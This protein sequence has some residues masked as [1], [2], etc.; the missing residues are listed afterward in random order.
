MLFLYL[1]PLLSL[2]AVDAQ[3]VPKERHPRAPTTELPPL[4]TLFKRQQ[5]SNKPCAEVSASWSAAV[6]KATGPILVP[7]K[8]AYDCLQSIPVDTQGDIKQ[9][10]ELKEFVQFQSNLNYLKDGIATHNKPL[11]VLGELDKMAERIKNGSYASEFQ[12]Q[13][14]LS[15]MFRNSGDNHFRWSP[16]VLT[17]LRFVRAVPY[18]ISLSKDGIELPQVYYLNDFNQQRRFNF[19]V[20]PIKTINGKNA[21]EYLQ[22]SAEGSSFHDI[23]A[24]YNSL[25]PNFASQSVAPEADDDG[26][27]LVSDSYVGD[28][29]TFVF[30]NGTQKVVENVALISQLFNFTGVTDGASFFKKFCTGQPLVKTPTLG[31]QVPTKPQLNSTATLVV[32]PPKRT[33]TGYPKPVIVQSALSIQGYFLNG[34][35]YDDVAILAVPNF[36]PGNKTDFGLVESQKVLRT[37]F[38]EAVSKNKKKLIIDLRGNPGGT[39]DLGYELF[40]QLFPSIDPYGGTRY[41]AHE[42]FEI[43]SAALSA[44]VT[45][46]T[47]AK[48][49][50]EVLKSIASQAGV[51][52]YENVRNANGTNFKSFRD[53]YGPYKNN[54]DY[55]TAIRRYNYSNP[56][57]Y[58]TTS[59]EWNITGYL[60]SRPAPP[61]PFLPQNIVLLQDGGCSST[62]AIFSELIRTQANVTSIAVGGR[63]LNAPMQAIGGTKGANVFGFDLVVELTGQ[64]LNLTT[65]LYGQQTANVMNNSAVGRVAATKQ[66]YIRSS[67]VGE[68]KIEG[69][70]NSLDN[71]RRGDKSET[72][73]EFV[74]EA[75]D[76]K[77]FY[78][79][80]IINDPTVLWKLA[81]QARWKGGKCV[82]GSLKGKGALTAELGVEFGAEGKEGSKT[83]EQF[84]GEGGILKVGSTMGLVVLV[85][86]LSSLL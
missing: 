63:P 20:S 16:D 17:P 50:P 61:Q 46:E 79:M 28:N 29:T 58:T 35:G 76:C 80:G 49:H 5:F 30:A 68:S 72:P 47:F 27:F 60:S 74:Y 12:V 7:A 42:A 66:L 82:E 45:N 65:Q 21:T 52:H 19:T 15:R 55:F 26:P 44:F 43:F 59:D 83:P 4:P 2:A 31:T 67:K 10:T 39:I 84:K 54:N 25:F 22:I 53:Y 36:A 32:N 75:A 40:K 62:C 38:A 1:L 70:V 18:L 48:S 33:P 51:F 85:G 23:D 9:I 71:I 77:L 24:K 37:F 86:F 14:E 64:L 8:V 34:T 56:Y 69:S 78:P 73:L 11:D 6:P 57:G 13:L 3:V 41:R 81:V